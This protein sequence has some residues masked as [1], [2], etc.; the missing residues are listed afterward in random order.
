MQ[1]LLFGFCFCLT[2]V[3]TKSAVN[4]T[5]LN[6]GLPVDFLS[7]SSLE[8]PG[9]A[10]SVVGA[11]WLADAGLDVFLLADDGRDFLLAD[12]GLGVSWLADSLWGDGTGE[13][14]LSADKNSLT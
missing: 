5:A 2:G 14:D 8:V 6:D 9:V 10:F 11:F 3:V 12:G 1:A 13:L 7:L 4:P